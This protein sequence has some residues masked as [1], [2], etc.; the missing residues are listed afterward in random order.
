M[1]RGVAAGANMPNQI[2]ITKLSTP[3]SFAVGTSG[4]VGARRSES[5]ASARTLPARI[6]VSADATATTT[7]STSPPI[8]ENTATDA[9]L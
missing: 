8:S 6:C 4:S 5:T 7:S 2:G 9:P 1:S 3:A